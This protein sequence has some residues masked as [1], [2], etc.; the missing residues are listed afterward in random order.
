V[1]QVSFAALAGSHGRA[2]FDQARF[3]SR[4]VSI[5]SAMFSDAE[6]DFSGLADWSLPP[7]FRWDGT[8]PNGCD[9][10][11]RLNLKCGS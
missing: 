10:A 5:I 7:K 8:L 1:I 3:V 4:P 2:D 11:D 6:V 9:T